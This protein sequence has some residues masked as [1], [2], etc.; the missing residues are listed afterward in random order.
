[1]H[2][3]MAGWGQVGYESNMY[4]QPYALLF[5]CAWLGGVRGFNIPGLSRVLA[6]QV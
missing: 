5:T 3:Y 6:L 1:M 2:V 4:P